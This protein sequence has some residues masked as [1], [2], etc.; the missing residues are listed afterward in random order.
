MPKEISDRLT[1]NMEQEDRRA[2][3]EFRAKFLRETGARLSLSAAAATLIR[4]GW[5]AACRSS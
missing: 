5:E 1:V 3:E 4:K 2:L